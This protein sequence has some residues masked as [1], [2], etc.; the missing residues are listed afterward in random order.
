MS[1]K[2]L[3]APNKTHRNLLDKLKDK[4]TAEIYKKFESR[5]KIKESFIVA[6]S[7]GPD[8]LALTF[9][10]QIY[11]IKHS[12]NVKYFIVNHKL[13]KNSLVEVKLVKK[14]LKK[15]SINLNVLNWNSIKPSG[16]IQS[17][18]RKNRYNLLI[19]QAKKL[20][21]NTLLTGHHLD[22]LYENFFIRIL[23]GS[24]LNGLISFDEKKHYKEINLIRPLLKFEKNDL[25]YITNKVF[26]YYIKDPSN[27][28]DKFTRVRLRK[29]IKNLKLEGLDVN[30]LF[31]TIKNLK[32]S[33]ETI[34]FYT[35]KN[36]TENSNYLMS[37]NSII[38]NKEFFNQ[39]HE[40]VLRSL[41]EI[42]KLI[43]KKHYHVRG[44][45]LENIIELINRD[46]NYPIKFTLGNCIL[47]KVNNSIIV[48]KEQ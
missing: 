17:I 9:L 34:K 6:V 12:L 32:F 27:H 5:L 22:D 36:L 41:M 42:I 20:K 25:K 18:A 26:G 3:N 47:N 8:S 33:N 16:N 45:K 2:N 23:R 46:S 38:L 31:L 30:K 37:E 7:G 21:I 19:N 24:G 39:P 35:K 11:S 14:L 13:R 15:F 48:S 10:T 28:D 44:K 40:I 4:K 29:L 43:G 1:P